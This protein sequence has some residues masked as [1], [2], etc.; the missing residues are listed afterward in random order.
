VSLFVWTITVG[1]SGK[2]DPTS[3]MNYLWNSSL[4]HLITQALP[5]LQNG[6]TIGREVVNVLQQTTMNICGVVE[7]QLHLFS[8]SD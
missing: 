5:L 3:S 1:L 4:D 7:V 2:G 8:F 6:D